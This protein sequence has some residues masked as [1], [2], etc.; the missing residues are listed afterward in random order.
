MIKISEKNKKEDKISIN[1]RFLLSHISFSL[2]YLTNNKN[3]N[4]SYFGKDIRKSQSA[5]EMFLIRM[6]E[7]CKQDMKLAKINGKISGCEPIPYKQ[8]S[9]S[10][11]AICD[12]V[13]IISKESILSVFR[14]GEN[15]Y[16]ILCK[17][18]LSHPN[19]LHIIAFDF[20]YSAYNH[21]S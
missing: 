15:K 10:M 9:L 4:F 18:D 14:F 6:Q 19:L 20:N 11:Q 2:K 16:R 21:G 1:N 13:E 12:S 17:T 5:Y 8:L 3:F 7:L